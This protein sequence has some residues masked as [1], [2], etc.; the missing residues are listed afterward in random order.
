M[1]DFA[2]AILNARASAALTWCL[3]DQYYDNTHCQRYGLWKFK[4]DDWQPRPAYY[5]WSLI[6]R[7]TAANSSVVAVQ[8]TPVCE[9]LRAAALLSPAG[10]LTI[11][12]VNRY[13]RELQVTLQAGQPRPVSLQ[14]YRY[15]QDALRTA[16]GQ[17]F[18]ASS[19]LQI[20]ANGSTNLTMPAQSFALL[21]E[22][23]ND[24]RDPT[25]AATGDHPSVSA[26]NPRSFGIR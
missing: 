21:T 7:Y 17:V 10:Q 18:R 3:F 19:E 24:E 9:S 20:A 11:L 26:E 14:V 22:F 25:H 12:V 1:G 8:M 5:S 4:D 2:I 23:P 6:N 15:T 13:D 16:T